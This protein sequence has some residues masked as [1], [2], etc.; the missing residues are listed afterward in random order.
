MFLV[1]LQQIFETLTIKD[2]LYGML[3]PSGNDAAVAVAEATAGSVE[4]FVTMMNEEAMRLGCTGT[5]FINPNGLP[6]ERHWQRL[7]V[8]AGL[9]PGH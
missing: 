1:L 9:G 8:P 5:H 3:M 6:D 7:H 2:L 4:Q